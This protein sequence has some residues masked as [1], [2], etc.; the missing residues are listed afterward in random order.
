MIRSLWMALLL[1][2]LPLA[3]LAQPPDALW[4]SPFDSL[5]ECSFGD[6]VQTSDGGFIACGGYGM[7]GLVLLRMN[8][9]GLIQWVR[10]WPHRGGATRVFEMP[11]GG[12]LLAGYVALDTS[13]ASSPCAFGLMR[14]NADGDSLWTVAYGDT[15]YWASLTDAVPL[16]DGGY[17]LTGT[18]TRIFPEDISR[19]YCMR[20]GSAYDLI[21]VRELDARADFARPAIALGSDGTIVIGFPVYGPSFQ[22]RQTTVGLNGEGDS[23][24]SHQYFG[25]ITDANHW[26]FKIRS[27]GTGYIMAGTFITDSMTF[28][29]YIMRLNSSGDS[30]WFHA[31]PDRADEA[32]FPSD[33]RLLPGGGYVIAS[34]RVTYVADPEW[35]AYV[36][37]LDENGDTLWTADFGVP[38][39]DQFVMAGTIRP[40]IDNGY[41]VIRSEESF[42]PYEL[43]T[44]FLRL[45]PDPTLT[46]DKDFIPHPSSLILSAFP[47]P[48]NAIATLSF[49]LPQAGNVNIDIFDV[50]G[51]LVKRLAERHLAPGEHHVEFDA[52]NL[53]S[54]LYF[55]R[56]QMAAR[57]MTH[58]LLLVK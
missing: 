24:W 12:F 42:S 43:S 5:D 45:G 8:D 13:S 17:V 29:G 57:S 19:V 14:T 39:A 48:F 55:A 46:A 31:L 36:L 22:F 6:I 52:D 27:E 4:V 51:R 35:S 49:T 53:P 10:T 38:G 16:P 18:R 7:N 37:R 21:W 25:P 20:I 47:N 11:D 1:V 2:C 56:L 44:S 58:K 30:V 28:A 33:F 9:E 34:Q 15:N 26:N 41:V 40:T 32:F 50:S 54:G 3:L 23:L